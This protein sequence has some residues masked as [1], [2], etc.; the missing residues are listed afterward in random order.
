LFWGYNYPRFVELT[1][2]YE[3]HIKLQMEKKNIMN[4]SIVRGQNSNSMTS[5]IDL[6]VDDGDD[7]MGIIAVLSHQIFL[8]I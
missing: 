5:N 1:K 4:V 3:L 7:M 8:L 6:D 2:Q